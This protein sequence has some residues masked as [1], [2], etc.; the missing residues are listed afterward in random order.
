MPVNLDKPQLWK[1]DVGKSVDQYNEWF[2]KFAPTTYRQTR[3]K[4]TAE[5]EAMLNR[6]KNL[7]SVTPQRWIVKPPG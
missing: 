5:V 4:V 1:Q 6:T 2:L 3:I 7:T